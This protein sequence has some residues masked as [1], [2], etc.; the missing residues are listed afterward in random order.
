MEK[1]GEKTA[2]FIEDNL[3]QILEAPKFKV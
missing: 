1:C 3:I 2:K